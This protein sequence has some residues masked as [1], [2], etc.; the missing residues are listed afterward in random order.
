MTAAGTR[1]LRRAGVQ[2]GT[3]PHGEDDIEGRT[4]ARINRE[5]DGGLRWDTAALLKVMIDVWA[6]VFGSTLG[7]FERSLVGELLEFRHKWAHAVVFVA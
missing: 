1:P 7:H 2:E 5:K 6:D 3:G 4:R